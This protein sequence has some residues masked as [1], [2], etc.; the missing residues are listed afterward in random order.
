MIRLLLYNHPEAHLQTTV[1][2]SGLPH[3]YIYPRPTPLGV[4]IMYRLPPSTFPAVK[5]S[6]AVNTVVICEGV[7]TSGFQ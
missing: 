4:I 2:L 5:Y 6:A 1:S 3:I 7:C